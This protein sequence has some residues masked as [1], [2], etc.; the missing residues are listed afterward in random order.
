MIS[1]I[2]GMVQVA[3]GVKGQGSRRVCCMTPKGKGPT[4]IHFL[5]FHKKSRHISYLL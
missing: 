2:R 1:V 5:V 3:E 4:S